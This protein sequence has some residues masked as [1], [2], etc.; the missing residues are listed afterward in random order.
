MENIMKLY[1]EKRYQE[2]ESTKPC[3][4]GPIVTISREFGCPS[5]AIA[6]ML[7]EALNKRS[8]KPSTPTWKYISKE[9]VEEAARKLDIKTIEMNYLISSGEKGLVE[10]LLTSFS[11]NYVSSRKIKKILN[12]VIRTLA[13]QGQLVI[14][15]RG[16]VAILQGC[17]H[18]L[19][20][21]LQAPLEW[22]V[23]E[24]SNSRGLKETEA[25]KITNETDQKRTAL[26]ELLLGRKFAQNLFDVI[27]NCS[28]FSKEEIVQSILRIMEV[29]KMI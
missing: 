6:Q 23:R 21:Q 3:G 14:V 5:K 16:S 10:D 8:I 22:R 13:M 27:F 7:T 11:P 18:V 26:I 28:T 25:L 29:R 24:I 2:Q 1:F 9:V 4:P 15:G 17:P 19:H 20:I 12:D